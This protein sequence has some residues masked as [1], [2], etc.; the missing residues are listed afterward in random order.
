LPE[1]IY[2]GVNPASVRA[3]LSKYAI[4]SERRRTE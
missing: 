4:I 1:N 2:D 3:F